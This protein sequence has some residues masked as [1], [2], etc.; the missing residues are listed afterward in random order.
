MKTQINGVE[1]TPRLAEVLRKWYETP[2]DSQPES[3]VR[4][5]NKIQD[6]LM[7][8]WVDK[9]DDDDEISELKECVN[10]LMII[11]DDLIDFIPEKQGGTQ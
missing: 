4:W 1:I 10:A 9:P 6:Y 7:R 5:I 11:K 8:V 2:N 3:Y